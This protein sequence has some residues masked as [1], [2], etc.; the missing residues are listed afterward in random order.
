[1]WRLITTETGRVRHIE[2]LGLVCEEE[3]EEM[4]RGAVCAPR[5]DAPP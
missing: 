4:F 2:T 1:M 3:E 5:R